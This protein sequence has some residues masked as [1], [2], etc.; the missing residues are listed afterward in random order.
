MPITHAELKRAVLKKTTPPA[1]RNM[2]EFLKARQVRLW[3]EHQPEHY[4]ENMLLLA[5]YKD[6]NGVGYDKLENM[7][8][9]ALPAPHHTVAHNTD[10]LREHLY[11]W[12]KQYVKPG[13]LEEWRAA[14][15]DVA[16]PGKIT[17]KA[18]I[19]VDTWDGKKPGRFT[20]SA[21]DIEWSHKTRTPARRFLTLRDGNRRFRM[22]IG[23][24]APKYGDTEP[25]RVAADV[26]E[27][28]FAG[29]ALVG[30]KK[31]WD[32]RKSFTK[33]EIIAPEPEK[34][35]R[36]RKNPEAGPQ[37]LPPAAKRRNANISSLRAR[38]EHDYARL[39]ARW[40]AL[41][42][43]FW[44]DSELQHKYLVWSHAAWRTTSL[45]T[46]LSKACVVG[47]S[48]KTEMAGRLVP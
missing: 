44:E 41:S 48:G 43:I 21:K 25:M 40:K 16:R 28:M 7:M 17:D 30:D 46:L 1:F 5:L 39:G 42:G 11:E 27:A 12:A 32:A 10:V 45:I 22:I 3:G 33:V 13:T 19:W 29:V 34:R 18:L 37:G 15:A 6:Q 31:F 9:Q 4:L 2:L 38:V 36:K 14:S 23:P 26:I 24:F 20:V 47:R 35:G 8:E